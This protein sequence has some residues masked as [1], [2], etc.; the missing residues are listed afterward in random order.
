MFIKSH[1]DG[2]ASSPLTPRQ[3]RGCAIEPVDVGQVVWLGWG[4]VVSR[5]LRSNPQ[6]QPSGLILRPNPQPNPQV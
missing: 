6:V 3:W 2:L 5:F 1:P 4:Q